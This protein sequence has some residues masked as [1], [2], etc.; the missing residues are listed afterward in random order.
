MPGNV[1]DQYSPLEHSRGFRL[2]RPKANSDNT[3]ERSTTCDFLHHSIDEA[4]L[5]S[6]LSYTWAS[7][8]LGKEELAVCGNGSVL[9]IQANLAA[10]INTHGIS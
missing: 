5:F 2:V 7:A 10:W 3:T 9:L 4:S 1:K 8:D 6:T